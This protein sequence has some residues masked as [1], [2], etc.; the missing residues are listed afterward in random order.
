[1][2]IVSGMLDVVTFVHYR[3]FASKQTGKDGSRFSARKCCWQ[4]VDDQPPGNVLFLT[5]YL[6]SHKHLRSKIEQNVVI[7]L[8]SY[9][10]DT[11]IMI[12]TSCHNEADSYTAS[13]SVILPSVALR[14]NLGQ[15]SE[16]GCFLQV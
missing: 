5:V 16:H 6:F 3:V 4:L 1:M 2:T 14:T 11:I 15:R 9:V 7:S 13:V 12:F 8:L 10:R